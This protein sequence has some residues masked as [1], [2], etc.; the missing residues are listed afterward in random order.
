MIFDVTKL[1]IKRHKH[2]RISTR[3]VKQ[4]D[5]RVA[6]VSVH[7]LARKNHKNKNSRHKAS[8]TQ[9]SNQFDNLAC[10]QN[11]E[12]NDIHALAFDAGGQGSNPN[13]LKH[14]QAMEVLAG[15]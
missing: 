5:I 10:L 3:K 1:T 8:S 2:Q 13:I 11:S 15:I 9:F 4:A 14:K 7:K 6:L 12:C